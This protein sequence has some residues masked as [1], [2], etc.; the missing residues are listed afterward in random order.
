MMA[1]AAV[2]A[3]PAISRVLRLMLSAIAPASAPTASMG[4]ARDI[5]TSETA[6]AEPVRS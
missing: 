3:W 5:S 4:T 2:A 1:P 6:K